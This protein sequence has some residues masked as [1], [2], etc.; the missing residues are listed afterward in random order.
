VIALIA[1]AAYLVGGCAYQRT[2][3]HQRGWRQCPNYSLWAGI[4]DFVKVSVLAL[5]PFRSF[6][7]RSRR[8]VPSPY[9]EFGSPR[10]PISRTD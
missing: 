2:V 7:I 6:R 1:V 3:M 4:F 10:L 5:I 9:K 8:G